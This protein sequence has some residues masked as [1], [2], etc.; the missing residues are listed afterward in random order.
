MSLQEAEIDT[1]VI[2]AQQGDSAAFGQ[3]YDHFIV[4]V[5]R[6]LYFRVSSEPIA[7]DLTAEVFFKA[8]KHIK[9]Y[10]K[11]DNMP[12]SAWLFR[13]A[14]NQLVDHYRKHV[15][16]EEI[17][18]TQE[19]ESALA[20]TR[21]M[22]VGNMD[23]KRILSAIKELPEMQAQAIVLKYFSDRKNSEIAAVLGKSE[24]AVRI[25]QSRGLRRLKDLLE[26]E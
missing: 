17:S 11:H 23:R 14:K 20:D 16:L 3:L 5:Y 22:T 10:Q 8:L 1:L 7:E 18:E 6:Y 2:R 15:P 12:F 4:M 19:D 26:F 24:T 9:K 13:I 21:V 25:L